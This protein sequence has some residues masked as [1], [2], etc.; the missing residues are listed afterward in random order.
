MRKTFGDDPLNIVI[1]EAPETPAAKAPADL[2]EKNKKRATYHL[3]TDIIDKVALA[4]WWQRETQA[5]I[6]ERAIKRELERMEAEGGEPFK[7]RP[8]ME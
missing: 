8:D 5:D 2:P 7:Q 4:A 3:S 6:V 1:P